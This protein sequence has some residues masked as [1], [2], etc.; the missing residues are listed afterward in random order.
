MVAELTRV[1]QAMNDSL[2]FLDLKTDEQNVA[3]LRKMLSGPRDSLSSAEQARDSLTKLVFREKDHLKEGVVVIVKN[4]TLPT[5][6][7]Q[8]IIEAIDQI[9]GAKLF[10]VR[11]Y[12]VVFGDKVVD[13]K[14]GDSKRRCCY[15][16][17]NQPPQTTETT[18]R[19]RVP[20]DTNPGDVLKVD[21]ETKTTVRVPVPAD[22]SP[23][24][25]LKVVDFERDGGKKMLIVPKAWTKEA[26]G[27]EVSKD[28]HDYFATDIDI[29]QSESK[30]D[31]ANERETNEETPI[32]AAEAL[33]ASA[34]S[35]FNL[36]FAWGIA[37]YECEW[38]ARSRA[39]RVALKCL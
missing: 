22:K 29:P 9:R 35:R 20:A 24:D 25:V 8:G 34:E 1:R 27:L 28:T 15:S 39:N 3:K 14:D 26:F 10:R 13:A 32:K 33:K 17:A 37:L 16:K 12:R 38:H 2:P 30:S 21:L 18:V 31:T 6:G 5:I 19:I 23:G 11:H 36:W 4:S 7:E